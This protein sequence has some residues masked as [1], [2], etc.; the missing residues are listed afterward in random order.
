VEEALKIPLVVFQ[1]AILALA[2]WKSGARSSAVYAVAWA[3]AIAGVVVFDV[4]YLSGRLAWS[5]SG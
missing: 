5:P 1:L 3:L 2:F 4:L